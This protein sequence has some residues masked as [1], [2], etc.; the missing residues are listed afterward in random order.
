MMTEE[1]Q[2]WQQAAQQ[3]LPWFR[4][5]RRPLA[6][7]QLDSKFQGTRLEGE[8][9]RLR[10]RMKSGDQVWPFEFH[11]R[12]YLGLRRGYVVLRDG[13]PIGGVVTEVS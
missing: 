3:G 4:F 13:R 2:L 11:V 8:W 12:R 1:A 5:L 7:E 9:L 10:S 6:L